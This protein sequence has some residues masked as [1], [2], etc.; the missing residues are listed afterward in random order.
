MPFC[1]NKMERL[2]LLF[3]ATVFPFYSCVSSSE[4]KNALN[5]NV[6][7]IIIDA[8]HGGKENGTVV[9]HIIDDKEITFTEKDMT[10]KI[11]KALAVCLSEKMPQMEIIL[12]RTEDVYMSKEER[13]KKYENIKGSKVIFVSIHLNYSPNKDMSGFEVYYYLPA[14]LDPKAY[15]TVLYS[16][17]T[18]KKNSSLAK[19]IFTV[20]DNIPELKDTSKSMKNGDYYVLKNANVPS[21]LIECGFL[22][23]EK[24]ALL[25]NT[26]SYNEKLIEG[27]ALGIEEYLKA[28]NN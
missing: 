15:I 12:T 7:T 20:I 21:V 11:A 3:I 24:E 16:M 5:H 17:D 14:L 4:I 9:T 22:S 27:I 13:V 10:L 8:G 6:F 23:N 18:I 1:E 26:E 2:I 25:L 19:S 28:K